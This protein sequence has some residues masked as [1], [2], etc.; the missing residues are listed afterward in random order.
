MGITHDTSGHQ[1]AL[2]TWSGITGDHDGVSCQIIAE[3]IL[4][5]AAATFD[6]TS[7]PSTYR[8]LLLTI[9][10]R[11][12]GA[13]SDA[14]VYMRLNNDS[15]NNYYTQMLA[16]VAAAATA[17]EY[18]AVSAMVTGYVPANTAGANISSSVRIIIPSYAMTTFQKTELSQSGRKTGTASGNLYSAA[19]FGT[20]ANTGAIN[21]VTILPSVGSF[22]TGTRATLWGMGPV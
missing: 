8:D 1:E 6:F 20:W 22:I 7:I 17:A 3:S 21:Q 19:G 11:S 5:G 18:L 16:G 10:G 13:A 15:G 14:I 4:S 2:V 12:D 9:D